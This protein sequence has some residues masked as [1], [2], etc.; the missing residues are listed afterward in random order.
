MFNRIL[1]NLIQVAVVM[2]FAPLVSGVLNRLKEMVQSKRGPSILQSYRDLWKLFH[3]DE[4]VSEESSWIFRFTPYL[5]FVAPI[6]VDAAD[7]G[8]DH[9][10]A[11]LCVHGRHA[12][13]RLRAGAGRLFRHA[14]RRGH[15]QSLR[16]H[17]RQPVRGWWASWPSR[18]S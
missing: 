13:G 16:S 5:V 3:K 11:V 12:G 10:P 1:F 7:S 14:G 4:I 17:R 2:A 8:A 9:L 18:C 15:G 6:F